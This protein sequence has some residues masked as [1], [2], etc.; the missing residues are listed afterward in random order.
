M[1][2]QRSHPPRG[3]HGNVKLVLLEDVQYLGKQG[4][5]VEVRPGYARN[6]LLPRG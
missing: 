4:D 5:L 2:K 1:V 6:F 3:R